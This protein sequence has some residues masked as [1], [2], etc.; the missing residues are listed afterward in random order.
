MNI[1]SVIIQANPENV[2]DIIDKIS[3][4]EICEYHLH[5]EKGKIIVTIEDEGVE[6]EVFK[7]QQIQQFEHVISADMVFSYSEDELEAEK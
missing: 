4:S 7:L 6:N 2:K 5:D 3:N 1:S